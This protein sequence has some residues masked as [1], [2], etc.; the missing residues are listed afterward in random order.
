VDSKIIVFSV[1]GKERMQKGRIVLCFGNDPLLSV[2]LK[3]YSIGLYLGRRSIRFFEAVVAL[4][5]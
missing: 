2:L 4:R 5:S 3:N 1:V